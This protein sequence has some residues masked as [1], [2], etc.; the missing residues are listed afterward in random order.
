M[1]RKVV[2]G[3]IIGVLLLSVLLT[4]IFKDTPTLEITEHKTGDEIGIIDITGLIVSGGSGSGFSGDTQTGSVSVIN[5]L[6][7]AAEN[8]N[9]KAVVLRINSPGGSPAASLEIGNEIQR[10]RQADKKV[11][12]YMSDMATSGAYWISCETDSI[13]A[14][15]T[16][17]TGSIGVIMQTMDLQGLYNIIGIDTNTF[18]SGA[19][20]DM[21]SPN[22]NV[23]EEERAIFQSMIEDIYLQFVEV[24]AR[25]R[26]M[27]EDQ[28]KK[29]A[30]GRVYT[31]RQALELGLVDQ[32]GD[33]QQAIQTAA[34]LA[35][36]EGE[37]F[38]VNLTPLTFWD[39]IFGQ[40]SIGSKSPLQNLNINPY[41]GPML[42]PLHQDT[43]QLSR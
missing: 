15:P 11:V 26:N 16:T 12:A 8:P 35:G 4:I 17:M 23:T 29:L 34:D 25:G 21:G 20:K 37:P 7:E 22:R 9:I 13:V 18:K 31:G 43:P 41:Y 40:I 32:L 24:V 10:L 27:E 3:L 6:R 38:T 36:V 5:Q 28:V 30:D 33:M 39:E 19:H 42:L 2:T 1:K 14:N